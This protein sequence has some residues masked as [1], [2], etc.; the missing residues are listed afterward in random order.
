LT[1]ALVASQ[2]PKS[3]GKDAPDKRADKNPGDNTG[4]VIAEGVGTTADDALKDAFRA[5]VRQTVGTM[6][7]AETLVRND[8]VIS[9]KVLTYSDGIVSVYDVIKRENRDGLY[10][11]TISARVERRRVAERLRKANVRV[12]SLDGKDLAAEVS[13]RK[14]AREGAAGLLQSVLKEAPDLLVAEAKRTTAKDYDDDTQTLSVEVRVK[15]DKNKYADYFRRLVQV[16]GKISLAKDAVSLEAIGPGRVGSV[17]RWEIPNTSVFATPA[18]DRF[19]K[20]WVFWT[21]GNMDDQAV[22]PR[23]N[24]YVIDAD[25]K[26]VVEPLRGS[27]ACRIVARDARGEAV[28]EVDVNLANGP[29]DSSSWLGQIL[30]RPRSVTATADRV[31]L[32]PRS[33]TTTAD[34]IRYYRSLFGEAK[35][36]ADGIVTEDSSFALLFAPLALDASSALESSHAGKY[37]L[38]YWPS[39]WYRTKLSLTEKQLRQVK[40]ISC[41][42]VF[43]PAAEGVGDSIDR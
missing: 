6:V 33:V 27:L 13:T 18:L 36:A 15:V 30:Q 2:L 8:T 42:V 35:N 3:A 29:G 24:W 20:G 12:R 37:R 38:A 40:E 25:F 41:K 11:V 31:S 1:F 28:G 34:H 22:R 23:W 7:D 19:P 43:K 14:D 32:R 26:K 17:V 10:R 9:D 5:A 16:L 4:R 39:L 21:V